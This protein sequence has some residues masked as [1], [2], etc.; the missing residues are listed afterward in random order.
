M[1]HKWLWSSKWYIFA[2]DI[3]VNVA[4]LI[5]QRLKSYGFLNVT[6]KKRK[7]VG[8]VIAPY[9]EVKFDK[10]TLLFIYQQLACHS[11]NEIKIEDKKIRIATIDISTIGV[12]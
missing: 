9:Y 3:V 2:G 4:L 11:Y 7:G 10:E 1:N 5:Q 12:S 6:I 8:E